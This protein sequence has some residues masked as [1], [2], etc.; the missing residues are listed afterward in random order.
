MA[1]QDFRDRLRREVEGAG[2]DVGEER[3]CSGAQDG[4]GRGEEAEGGGND[5]VRLGV[6]ASGVG[7]VADAAAASASQRA[8]VPLAQPMAKRAAQAL[9]A[10]FSKAATCGPRMKCCESQT[11]AMA[12]RISCRSGANWREKS[13]MG[14]G[15][16]ADLDTVAMVHRW[17]AESISLGNTSNSLHLIKKR[18][19][20]ITISHGG[21]LRTQ[22]RG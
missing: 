6:G 9:A 21:T 14:T 18:T 5:G 3:K 15:C 7:T 4:A 17:T 10:A 12:T 1:A 2:I 20:S 19:E 22:M 11:L 16:G 8:S 13:S